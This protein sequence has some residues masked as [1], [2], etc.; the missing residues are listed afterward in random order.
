M[1]DTMKFG[2]SLLGHGF[3]FYAGVPCSYLK[4]IINYFINT[5]EYIKAVNE[6]DA[7]AICSGAYMGGKRPIVMMQNS[8]LANAVSPLSSLNSIFQI[9]V[10]GFVSLRGETGHLDEPQ[11]K[12]MGCITDKILDILGIEWEF[13]SDHTPEALGQIARVVKAVPEGRSFFFIVRKNTFC[14]VELCKSPCRHA[15]KKVLVGKSKSDSMPL[16]RE[17]LEIVKSFSGDHTA[18]IATTGYTGRELYE[19]GDHNNNFYMVGSMGCASSIALGFAL[20]RKNRNVIAIDGDGALLM[21]MGALATN[22]YYKPSNMLHLVLDNNSYESTGGQE[23]VSGN[24]DFAGL[25]NKAGYPRALHAHGL[26]ELKKYLEEW[27]YDQA[28]TF[29][30]IKI[31]CGSSETLKRPEILPAE[32]SKRLRVFFNGDNCKT[33]V[34]QE[35]RRQNSEL[36]SNSNPD[37]F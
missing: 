9:P 31:R 6:G 34:F 19:L 4:P 14:D 3:D 1:I 23:T 26:D 18:L 17:V 29:I 8:G 33:P 32:V 5:G 16:R 28:L 12:L 30:N 36:N 25:A 21:R 27:K 37:L 2:K 10:L 24:V 35:L 22:A 7:V 11:H 13:L 15:G 20:A